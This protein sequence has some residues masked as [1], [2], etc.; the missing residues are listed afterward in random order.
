MLEE[1]RNANPCLGN[2]PKVTARLNARLFALENSDSE[3][4]FAKN[5]LFARL[6]TLENSDAES[7]IGKV[8][9]ASP[10]AHASPQPK[11]AAFP[12]KTAP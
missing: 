5:R 7:S 12:T 3:S 9:H 2:A 8:P 1:I 10:P 6:F 4:V 11:E